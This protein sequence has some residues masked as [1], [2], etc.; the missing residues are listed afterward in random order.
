MTTASK[1]R[2][3]WVP[4]P[5]YELDYEHMVRAWGW[6]VLSFDTCGSY[7][8]DHVV[9]LADG[10]RR[11]FLMIGYGSCTGCDALEAARPY[12][13]D[14]E[15]PA[16]WSEV[17][18]IYERLRGEVHWEPDAASLADWIEHQIATEGSGTVW[19][20]YDDEVKNVSRRYVEVLRSVT[21]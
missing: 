21:G 3:A 20:W 13:Y 18:E 9:L 12:D 6:T 8:G 1:P 4:E 10:D 19:Y 17:V 14:D 11:G 2:P 16:D 5:T 15:P 7:Q